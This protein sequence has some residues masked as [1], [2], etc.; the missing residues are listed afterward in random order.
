MT[1]Q[2]MSRK[3]IDEALKKLAKAKHEG[4]RYSACCYS[5]AIRRS[6]EEECVC[7]GCGGTFNFH[8]ETYTYDSMVLRYRNLAKDFASLGFDVSV[9]FYCRD[10]VQKETD[11][12]APIV[13][14]FRLSETEDPV[15]SYP[16]Y[17]KYEDT[18]YLLAL[19]FL[20]GISSLPDFAVKY[21]DYFD[22][23]Y[24]YYHELDGADGRV[25]A[26]KIRNIIGPLKKPNKLPKDTRRDESEY[27]RKD[28]GERV[29][30]RRRKDETEESE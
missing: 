24:I 13:F 5:P 20:N 12:L 2:K 14:S 1:I 9:K 3:Q 16:A 6:V 27:V 26:N 4:E 11:S 28:K 15:L 22:V 30:R 17:D 21:M 25:Y 10:C 7:D 29:P 19:D 23:K 18:D 8:F